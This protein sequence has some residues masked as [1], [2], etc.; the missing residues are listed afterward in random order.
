MKEYE[1]ELDCLY[2]EMKSDVLILLNTNK[3]FNLEWIY[4]IDLIYDIA[5][6]AEKRGVNKL[7]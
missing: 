1:S 3:F 5:M 4:N 2:K 7:T 6:E